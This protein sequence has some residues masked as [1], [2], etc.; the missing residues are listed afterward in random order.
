MADEAES[1]GGSVQGSERVGL[2]KGVPAFARLPEETLEELAGLL[3]EE[4]H[5]AGGVVVAEGDRGD[6][7]YLISGGHAEVSAEGSKGPVPLATLG[8][9]EM[10]G[11]IALLE[12]GGKRQA[13]VT[14]T[15]DLLTLSL[16]A[17]AFHRV[18]DAYPE[19]RTAFSEAAEEMLVAKFLKQASPFATLDAD[20]L[21][22]LASRLEHL[23]VSVG[24]VIVRQG[25]VGEACYLLRSGRVEVVA[26]KGEGEERN[27]ATL[28]PGSLFVEAA[29]LTDAPRNA[30]VRAL[31]PCELLALRR[32]DLLEALGEDRQVGDRM[33]EMLRMRD[34]PRQAPGVQVHHR[35]TA[36]GE[37]ITTLKDPRRGTYY[38]LSP[39]GWFVW[40][41]L[42]GEHTLRDLT[43]EYLTEFKAFAPQAVAEAVGGMAEAG[44]AEGV[45]PGAGVMENVV[46]PLGWQRATTAAR[47]ILEWHTSI[48]GVD[49]PIGRLYRSGVRLLYTR[50][51]QTVLAL[52][53]LAGL[54]AFV[55]GVGELG[56]AIEE[57]GAGG[58]LLLF[59][60]PATLIQIFIHEAGHAF[61]TKH[62]G[63]EVPRVGVGWYWFGPIAY[64]DTSDMWLAGRRERVIVSLA[65]PYADLITGGLAAIVAWLV[66]SPVLSAALW[67]FALVSYIGVLMNLNPLMEFDGYYVLSDLL[68]KP[69]LR[70]RALAWLGTGLIPALRDPTK[71]R[72][73]RLELLYGLSSVLYIAVEIVLTLVLYRLILQDWLSG[74]LTASV[75]AALVWV[76]AAGV[77]VLA[78]VGMLGELRGVRRPAPGR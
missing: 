77:V 32:S 68:D 43:L 45:K 44:F 65:G 18:L 64:A 31:E 41:R 2:L 5:P 33:L 63:Q 23:S 29:L 21:R 69:N 17:P 25:E 30:T 67:Q 72:G 78:V 61:T 15:T 22:W 47:R 24:D 76:L 62:F 4:R 1:V 54:V 16:S 10:F 38:R 57:S 51:G 71:L 27:L 50:V 11:E 52:I 40:E 34:R 75:A 74:L 55:L 9:G 28:G 70:P 35:A 3:C 39:G 37:T 7:L 12:P 49:A 42:D 26:Q 48:R 14:A 73:H 46:R 8:P 6:R 60:I 13:T 19:A 66:P 53:A 56:T 20:R 36:T 58:W 59:W